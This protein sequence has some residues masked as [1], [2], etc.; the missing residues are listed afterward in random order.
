[1]GWL[2]SGVGALIVGALSFFAGHWL[3]GSRSRVDE[4]KR[5]LHGRIGSVESVATKRL[6]QLEQRLVRLIDALPDRYVL[7]DD[8]IRLV[9]RLES[10]V[11]A[12][13]QSIERQGEV[14]DRL[15][16]KL[17]LGLRLEEPA[18]EAS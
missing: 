15:A 8:Y 2:A 5:D 18:G 14:L 4:A 10:R 16:A 9:M 12:L 11:D 6:D 1:M 3:R 13:G 7:K 17:G